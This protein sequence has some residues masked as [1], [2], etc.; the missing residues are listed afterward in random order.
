MASAFTL[1]DSDVLVM[2]LVTT[3]SGARCLYV[4]DVTDQWLNP[5]NSTHR[6]IFEETMEI[7]DD[8]YQGGEVDPVATDWEGVV[9]PVLIEC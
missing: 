7:P 6:L 3:N 8:D 1:P 9:I 2:V 4:Y 5:D